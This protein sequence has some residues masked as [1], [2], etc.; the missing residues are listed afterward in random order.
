MKKQSKVE[1]DDVY[2]SRCCNACITSVNVTDGTVYVCHKCGELCK[3]VLYKEPKQS[4]ENNEQMTCSEALGKNNEERGVGKDWEL[5]KILRNYDKEYSLA[6]SRDGDNAYLVPITDKAIQQIN[7]W[8]LRKA[9]K[10]AENTRRIIGIKN[11]SGV[12]MSKDDFDKNLKK[13]FKGD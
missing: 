10:C 11:C 8:A 7:Q 3:P 5:R 9:K 4:N 2:Y 6:Q 12:L 1:Y 13:Q